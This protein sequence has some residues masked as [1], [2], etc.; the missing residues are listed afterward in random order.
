MKKII[1]AIT[2]ASGSLIAKK[3]I[4]E[5]VEL[6]H[7]VHLLATEQGKKVYAFEL[8]EPI[9]SLSQYLHENPRLVFH[10]NENFFSP[11]A[12]GSYPVDAMVVVPCS[13]GTLGKIKSVTSDHLICRAADVM[14]KEKRPLVLVVRET[15]LSSLHLENMLH[16]S[17]VG[18]IIMPPVPAYYHK[19][20]SIDEMTRH[21]VGRILITLG[22]ENQHH[23]V[24]QGSL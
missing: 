14:L 20:S 11:L 24:W 23:K 15:P 6:G 12:S 18:A 2:G 4:L 16:L 17:R 7:E 21:T 5:L 1:V 22:I 3:I 8:E 13:M 19:P 10:N 9:E